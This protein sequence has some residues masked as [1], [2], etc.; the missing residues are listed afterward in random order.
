MPLGVCAT[1][2][3]AFLLAVCLDPTVHPQCQTYDMSAMSMIS[4]HHNTADG[5]LHLQAS[6]PLPDLRDG[7]ILIK[8]IIR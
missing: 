4:V 1:T 7:E 6:T 5:S 3:C 8:V 2:V